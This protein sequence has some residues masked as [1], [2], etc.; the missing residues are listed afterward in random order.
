MKTFP[1]QRA[2]L[3]TAPPPDR[4][5][6]IE[7]LWG[8]ETVG[9]VGGE[10]KA[11]KS[12]LALDMAV[13]VASGRPCLDRFLV[14]RAGRVL[15]YAAEDSQ[16]IVRQRLAYISRQHGLDL[17]Q[18]D[19]WVITAPAVRLDVPEDRRLLAA[20]VE[21]L[22]PVLLILDPFV[23]LHRIDEN[24]SAEVVPLLAA[25]RDLQRRFHCS[26]LIVHHARKG[27]AGVRSGQA[28]RGSSEFHAWADAGIFLRWR[29]DRLILSTE[30]R[31]HPALPDLPLYL[32]EDGDD[33]ALVID[34]GQQAEPERPVVPEPQRILDALAQLGR[35]V[36]LRCLREQCRMKTASL[37]DL[38]NELKREG[39]VVNSPAGWS[40]AAPPAL[41]P[42]SQHP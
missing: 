21:T 37:C 5:W 10:P 42:V 19:L 1:V 26:V 18:L 20:T 27:A 9:I 38:L 4:R 6:L 16:A 2:H 7:N 34:T 36:S 32:H 3:L 39:K 29:G 15:L 17:A 33:A 41:F 31:A 30:H 40:L 23:R 13:A 25:L 14:R 8:D 22:Q 35:A 28:L 24:A 11:G 12:L